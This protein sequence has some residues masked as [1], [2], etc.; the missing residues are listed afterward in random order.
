M[1]TTSNPIGDLRTF[2]L[3][4]QIQRARIAAARIDAGYYFTDDE[5]DDELLNAA[6]HR[7][8]DEKN[9]WL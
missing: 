5:L 3:D 2:S 4:E 1:S 8:S 9:E 6:S 7:P